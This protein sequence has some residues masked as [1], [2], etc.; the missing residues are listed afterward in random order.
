MKK[1]ALISGLLFLVVFLWV[2]TFTKEDGSF[3]FINQSSMS[4]SAMTGGSGQASQ[5]DTEQNPVTPAGKQGAITYLIVSSFANEEQARKM[6]D[7]Y[8]SRYQADIIVLP[9]TPGGY[10]RISYGSYSS[11][12][13]AQA[14]L[15]HLKHNGFPDAWLL[16]SQ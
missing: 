3:D 5:T 9:P 13:E 14:A 8:S 16:T 6:A 15:D 7:S 10:Y 11:P 12:E 1:I 4:V 2:N